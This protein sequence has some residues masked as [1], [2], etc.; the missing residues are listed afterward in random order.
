MSVPT[1]LPSR[2]APAAVEPDDRRPNPAY[3]LVQA[4]AGLLVPLLLLRPFR[5][6][7]APRDGRAPGA[8][9]ALVLFAL[10]G[11]W[12]LML[13]GAAMNMAVNGFPGAPEPPKLDPMTPAVVGGM[14]FRGA[15]AV[16][17]NQL[18]VILVLDF[19]FYRSF[20][21]LPDR[22]GVFDRC[23]KRRVT[24]GR[25]LWR[26]IG[27]LFVI[28]FSL[29]PLAAL[30]VALP[31]V[32]PSEA[33]LTE[34]VRRP[35]SWVGRTVRRFL[36]VLAGLIVLVALL[37]SAIEVVGQ[38]PL[39]PG[40]QLGTLA[41]KVL[42]YSA[43]ELAEAL[44]GVNTLY[45]E[46][47]PKD[48]PAGET[49]VPPD[50][51]LEKRAVLEGQ[52]NRENQKPLDRE[53]AAAK[54]AEVDRE[55]AARKD[56]SLYLRVML[57]PQTRAWAGV[58][59]W[60]LLPTP[61][62]EH[63]PF[64][65]LFVYATDLVLLLLIGR[66]PLAYNFRYLWVRRRDTA[67]TAVAFTVVVGV[68]VVLLAF[69]NGMY[70]LNESTGVPGN[71][72][73]LADGATDELFSN[74]GYGDVSN[75]PQ[76]VVT[77]DERGRPI[78]PVGVARGV[79]GPDGRVVEVPAGTPTEKEPPGTVRLASYETYLV[80]NQPVPVA[81]GEPA[82]RRFL[83]VRALKSPAIAAAVHNIELRPGGRW[84]AEDGINQDDPKLIPCVLG[85][86]AA[87]TLGPD[88][89]KSRLGPGDTFR[90]G[91]ADWVVLGVMRTEGTTFGSEVWCAATN[92]PV[93]Q[94]SGKGNKYTTLVLRMAENTTAASRAMAYHLQNRYDQAKLKAYSEPAY[95]SELTKTNETFLTYIVALALV[96][97]LGGVFGVMNT[98][99]ASIAARIKEV[100]VLRILG[101]KRWQILISFML[102]SLAIAFVGGAVGCALGYLANGFEASSTL[103]G[104]QG[105]GKSVSLKM[106]VDYQTLAAGMMF[107]VVM[108]RLGGLVPAMSA[109]RMEIL[110][111][112]R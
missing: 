82:K 74:L 12:L 36:A 88:A 104:G 107:T 38:L 110:E 108:G 112:L 98:M 22:L 44:P 37:A 29:L 61:M 103:S 77:E 94:A 23:L 5:P 19:L 68:V 2:L 63:W 89:G 50:D 64:V 4:V 92:N 28:G 49:W 79:I 70:K 67:L 73:V 100:G 72:L 80:M 105:G 9:A 3:A 55:I 27:T 106:V 52:A 78:A 81:E 6:L 32:A 90:L 33:V 21:R 25:A 43:V 20:P 51:L 46:Q 84:F 66:V 69:V 101:F 111:S 95:Y 109:M 45:A 60:T 40:G 24:F 13:A 47:E 11:L 14:V 65:F 30:L 8:G 71:V 56:K 34:T 83:Q 54:L 35:R 41:K 86:G 91:D 48:L 53:E 58:P 97:A 15:L 31:A 7:L 39:P 1:A 99:F 16:L 10:S 93:V 62:V 18:V 59:F 26:L 57:D 76:V 102:E 75:V 96:M 87:G 17:Q 85:E 42:G